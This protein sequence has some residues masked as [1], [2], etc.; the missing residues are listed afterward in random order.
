MDSIDKEKAKQNNSNSNHQIY[1]LFF[2]FIC[3]LLFFTNLIYYK[4][5]NKR[6]QCLFMLFPNKVKIQNY[7]KFNF[8]IFSEFK[9]ITVIILLNIVI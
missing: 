2:I 3:I 4:K 7:I 1:V 8:F 9:F 5:N 6:N